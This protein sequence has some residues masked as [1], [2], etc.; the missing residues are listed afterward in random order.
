MKKIIFYIDCMYHGGAQRVMANLIEYMYDRG[1]E[2]ILINDFVQEKGKP[3]YQIPEGV[4]RIYLRESINGNKILKNIV[5]IRN[6]RKTVAKEKPDVVLS[7]LGRP[8]KRL[9]IATVGLKVKKTVSVRNDPEKEYGSSKREKWETGMLFRLADGCVFQTEDAAAYFPK[10]VQKRAKIIL[11]PVGGQFYSTKRK[12]EL[13]DIIAVGRLEAQKNH[14]LLIDAFSDISDEFPEE[15]LII[16][17]DGPLRI[18]LESYAKEIGLEDRVHFLG[19]IENVEQVLS[20]AKLF[21]LSS[22]Y[23]GLPNALME[24]MAMGVPCISTDC[25]CGGPGTLIKNGYSGF[26]IRCDDRKQLADAISKLLGDTDAAKAIGE[27]AKKRA[28]DFRAEKIYGEWEDY[29]GNI[30]QSA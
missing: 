17:G 25:P 13:K 9:L 4:R 29:L 18:E 12:A 28:Q 20:G 14:K 30:S 2:V 5:R 21:V 11:N 8:N 15:D 22:E 1:Y 6:L 23:E 24:A 10:S 7:F 19:D 27:N 16:C 26:L 3:Q